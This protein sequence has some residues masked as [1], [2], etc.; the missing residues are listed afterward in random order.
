MNL[1]KIF[2]IAFVLGGGVWILFAWIMPTVFNTDSDVTMWMFF[3]TMALV[4]YAVLRGIAKV[5]QKF[6]DLQ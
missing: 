4:I 2:D 5:F 1:V 3:L 6:L